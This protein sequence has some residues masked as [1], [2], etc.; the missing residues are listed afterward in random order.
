VRFFPSKSGEADK[1]FSHGFCDASTGALRTGDDGVG[2]PALDL[3][4]LDCTS[5][6]VTI[7]TLSGFTW[8]VNVAAVASNAGGII[9]SRTWWVGSPLTEGGCVLT[10]GTLSIERS[11]ISA[12]LDE[13]LGDESAP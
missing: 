10:L 6:K 1:S 11:K 3:L 13:A 12:G 9:S 5:L 4:S 7:S 2:E 8:S